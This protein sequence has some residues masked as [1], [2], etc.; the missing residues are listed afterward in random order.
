MVPNYYCNYFH[1]LLFIA[2]LCTVVW[3]CLTGK[4]IYFQMKFSKDIIIYDNSK[5]FSSNSRNTQF[6]LFRSFYCMRLDNTYIYEYYIEVY[7]LCIYRDSRSKVKEISMQF[8]SHCTSGWIIDPPVKWE[9][10][11]RVL[12]NE[13]CA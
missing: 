8:N 11:T 10:I 12:I 13:H 5:K 1:S 7:I 9:L 2:I 3:S 6:C 4:G